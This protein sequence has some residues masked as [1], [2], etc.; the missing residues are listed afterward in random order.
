MRPYHIKLLMSGFLSL[1][2][3]LGMTYLSKEFNWGEGYSRRPI[4][5]YLLLYW[6][7]FV[8]YSFSVYWTL[9][10]SDDTRSLIVIFVLGL[11]FRAILIPSQQIQEDDVYRYLWDG[12]TF[13][14]QIN[15]YKFSPDQVTYFKQFMIREPSKFKSTYD[16]QSIRNLERLATLKWEN[17]TSLVFMERI[18]H[19]SLPT[20]YPPMAQYVFSLIYQ[21]KPDSIVAMRLGFLAFDLMAA[22]FILL[23][24]GALAKKKT[25]VIIYFWSPLIIKETFNSTHLDIIGIGLLCGAIYFLV[26]SRFL[27]A[28]IFLAFSVLGKLYPVVLFPFFLREQYRRFGRENFKFAVSTFV[29]V[30]TIFICYLPFLDIGF[31]IFSS[32]KSFSTYWQSN[33]SL[34]AI[35]VWFYRDV[36][37]IAPGGP[38]GFSYD[39]PSLW[40]KGTVAVI[41]VIVW[42]FLLIKKAPSMEKGETEHPA[43][44]CLRHLFIIMALIF[45]LSPV[46]NPWYLSWV[47]PFMC[48][49]PGRAWM[50]LTGLMGLYYLE[51]YFDYQDM[52][53]YVHWI[54][55]VEYMPF[56]VLLVWDSYRRNINRSKYL[57]KLAP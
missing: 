7:L 55:W 49:F 26:K 5:E 42:S 13:G 43:L 8:I 47:V 51:F 6:G 46:Q 2:F 53:Q 30:G 21:M 37:G 14:N 11:A 34:F 31:R 56:Y 15:P 3:Y 32:L 18:N 19:P 9:K 50:L 38:V 36:A 28:N 45:L 52:L 39:E 16:E 27:T 44:D 25:L 24:L 4:L 29:F 1:L 12:K 23:T 33:D 54:P 57:V 41:L 22:G 48:I 40:A 20:I 10:A 17:E 35:L